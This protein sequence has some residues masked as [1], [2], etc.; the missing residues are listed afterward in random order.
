[1]AATLIYCFRVEVIRDKTGEVAVAEA[2]VWKVPE[3]KDYPEGIKYSLYLV[4]K[5]TGEIVVGYDNH[6]PKGHH[7]HKHGKEKSYNFENDAVLVEEFW[8]L[9]KEEGFEI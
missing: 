5:G 8:D 3:S 7:F 4:L 9:V 2:K 6:K 1:M